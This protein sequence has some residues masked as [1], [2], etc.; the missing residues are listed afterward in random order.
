MKVAKRKE[1]VTLNCRRAWHTPGKDV[2]AISR[3]AVLTVKVNLSRMEK[4][5]SHP[6]EIVRP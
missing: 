6:A 1:R 5:E 2:V 4:K 3:S